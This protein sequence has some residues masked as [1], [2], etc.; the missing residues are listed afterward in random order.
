MPRFHF[1][2]S[3]DHNE[4]G[5]QPDFGGNPKK[6][7]QK[8]KEKEMKHRLLKQSLLAILEGSHDY[9]ILQRDNNSACLRRV[10]LQDAIKSSCTYSSL[11]E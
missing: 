3:R 1:S 6:K 11:Q 9:R 4:E 10:V 2:S 5:L 8:R 7:K